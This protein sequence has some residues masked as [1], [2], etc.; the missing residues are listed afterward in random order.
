LSVV[1]PT[2]LLDEAYKAFVFNLQLSEQ[3]REQL[4]SQDILYD[5]LQDQDNLEDLLGEYLQE[6]VK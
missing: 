5:Q 2:G 3:Q 4:H 6:L 1:N